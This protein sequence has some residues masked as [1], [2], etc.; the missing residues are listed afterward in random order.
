MGAGGWGWNMNF[1]GYFIVETHRHNKKI[2]FRIFV[3][4]N[5]TQSNFI[6]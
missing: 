1:L 2:L 6:E 5:N 4:K 3:V